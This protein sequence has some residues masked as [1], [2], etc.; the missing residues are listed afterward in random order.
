MDRGDLVHVT[1]QFKIV[2]MGN[3]KKLNVWQ[4]A[5]SLCEEVYLLTQNES[6]SKDFELRNQTRRSAIS[7][8]SNIA[9]GEESGSNKQSIRYF[10]IAKGSCAELLTQLIIANRIKYISE[11]QFSSIEER[12]NKI[13]AM[14]Y[15]LIESRNK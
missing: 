11:N 3:F 4:E 10:N 6:Y 7:I 12:C 5:I 1:N 8:P 2:Y 13:S 9:E 14:L 15:R